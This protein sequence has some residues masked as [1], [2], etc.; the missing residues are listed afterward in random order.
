MLLTEYFMIAKR[1]MPNP[2][3]KPL[4]FSWIIVHA[5]TR[6]GRRPGSQNLNPARDLHTGNRTATKDAGNVISALGSVKEK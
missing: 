1:S 4:Y 3:A 2:K 6:Q 5:G